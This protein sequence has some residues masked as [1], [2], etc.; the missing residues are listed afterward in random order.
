MVGVVQQCDYFSNVETMQRHC[1]MWEELK[2]LRNDVERLLSIAT[3][4][5]EHPQH[6]CTGFN[7]TPFSGTIY[8]F[9]APQFKK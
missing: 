5:G 9:L 6:T 8:P 1:Q 4:L 3:G 2:K 7:H